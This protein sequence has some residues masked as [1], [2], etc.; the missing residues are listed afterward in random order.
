M[1]YLQIY[2]IQFQVHI[3]IFLN[4]YTYKNKILYTIKLSIVFTSLF[5]TILLCLNLTR[6]VIELKLGLEFGMFSKQ[7]NINKYFL[8]PKLKLFIKSLAHL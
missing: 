7:I 3:T 6:L 8:K 1:N 5:M 4:K 2:T